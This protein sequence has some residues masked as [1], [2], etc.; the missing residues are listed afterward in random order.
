MNFVATH[1]E[2][3]GAEKVDLSF[4]SHRCQSFI[5]KRRMDPIVLSRRALEVCVFIHL[6]EAL[7]VGDI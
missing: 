6:A 5:V 7:Q 1:T 2:Q 3:R 4:A